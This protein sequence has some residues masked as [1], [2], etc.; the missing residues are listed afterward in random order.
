M[1]ALIISLLIALFLYL[2]IRDIVIAK[3]SR[4][5]RILLKRISSKFDQLSKETKK[6]SRLFSR[7]L[8]I[9]SNEEGED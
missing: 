3:K 2:G 7:L 9:L 5:N 6:Q 1:D 4:S 8:D